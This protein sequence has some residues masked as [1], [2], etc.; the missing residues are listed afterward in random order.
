MDAVGKE[1]REQRYQATCGVCKR[2]LPKK[3]FS[4]PVW[5]KE[6]DRVCTRCSGE[7]RAAAG[8]AAFGLR[9]APRDGEVWCKECDTVKPDD[10]FASRHLEGPKRRENAVCK[11]CS[12]RRVQAGG[13]RGAEQHSKRARL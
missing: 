10:A 5:K 3:A 4:G 2:S 11:E 8:G 1:T 6:G 7:A 13:Q 12:R 9:A